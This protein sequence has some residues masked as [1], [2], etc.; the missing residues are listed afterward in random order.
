MCDPAVL[1]LGAWNVPM[2]PI[3]ATVALTNTG[4]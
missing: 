1:T 2:S 3:P 4:C